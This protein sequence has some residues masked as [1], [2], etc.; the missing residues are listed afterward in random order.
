MKRRTWLLAAA[1]AT[2]VAGGA[3]VAAWRMRG[4]EAVA[5]EGIAPDL[6][7]MSFERLDGTSLDMRSLRGRPL[8]LN[9]WATW[10]APCV[11]ELPLLDAFAREHAARWNVLA[12]AVD[13][14]DPVRRFAAERALQLPMA[15]AGVEGLELSRALGNRMS[16]L[17]FSLALDSRGRVVQR[18]LGSL[19][20]AH[21]KEWA[22]IT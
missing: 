17:P 6:W 3:G 2:G 21:L 11:T 12:L 10:C 9:F 15:L 19:E 7:S 4:S 14:P 22:T 8:L 1:A 20:P 13:R 18:R 5:D 16:A